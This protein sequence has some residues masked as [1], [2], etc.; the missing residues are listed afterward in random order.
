MRSWRLQPSEQSLNPVDFL[1]IVAAA[2]DP[3]GA[4][5]RCFLSLTVQVSDADR[6]RAGHALLNLETLAPAVSPGAGQDSA[7]VL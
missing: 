2:A 6:G 4:H 5:L 1:G 3:D 7:P